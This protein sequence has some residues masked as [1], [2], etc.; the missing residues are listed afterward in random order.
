[1]TFLRSAREYLCGYL[2]WI[3]DRIAEPCRAGV[4]YRKDGRPR[5]DAWKDADGGWTVRLGRWEVMKDGPRLS[6]TRP[7]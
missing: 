1:M 4:F 6:P 3:L 2:A 5:V 7:L